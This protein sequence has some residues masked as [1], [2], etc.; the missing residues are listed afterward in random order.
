MLRS[1]KAIDRADIVLLV[2]DAGQGT[3]EQDKKIAGYI[4]E[5]GKGLVIVVNKWDLA[6]AQDSRNSFDRLVRTELDFL[7]FA[8]IHYV[9]ATTGKGVLKILDQIDNVNQQQTK[10]ISTGNLN[11][12]LNETLCLNPPPAV[13][14][15]DVKIYY[16]AQVSIKPPTLVFFV[17]KPEMLH[18]SYKRYLERRLRESYGFEG[19]PLQLIFRP[20]SSRG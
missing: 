20:R 1:L 5:A 12:W 13:K 7:S 3:V 4:Q 18:F 10:R 19:T 15:Q 11:T 16:V 17:N 2:L 6:E 9:S 14:G 8:A